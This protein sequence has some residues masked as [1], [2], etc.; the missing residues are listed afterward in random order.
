MLVIVKVNGG[1]VVVPNRYE[2]SVPSRYLYLTTI[3]LKNYCC[4]L[5]K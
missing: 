1:H 3:L 5:T 4:N 2:Q